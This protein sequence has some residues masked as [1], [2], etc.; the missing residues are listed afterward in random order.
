MAETHAVRSASGTIPAWRSSD[1]PC[2]TSPTSAATSHDRHDPMLVAA[3]AAGDLAGT[4]RDQAIALTRSCTECA[5]LHDDLLALARATAAAA[6]ADRHAG[7][8]LPADAGAMPR[9]LR[10]SGWRRFVAGR[11]RRRGSLTRPLGVGLATFGIA[12]LLIGNAAI[13]FGRSAAGRT[14][15][16]R[17]LRATTAEPESCPRTTRLERR[18]A[19]GPAAIGRRRLG[20]ARRRSSSRARPRRRRAARLRSSDTQ[21]GAPFGS[22]A[23]RS[24]SRRALRRVGRGREQ[25]AGRR[26]RSDLLRSPPPRPRRGRR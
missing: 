25:G 17:G 13:G 6:A 19:A 2:P 21:G 3:L 9:G 26:D 11:R 7:P 23:A 10:P 4:E 20:G 16:G 18:P 1:A 22:P 8:R 24:A 5:A 15:G 14:G 12:G